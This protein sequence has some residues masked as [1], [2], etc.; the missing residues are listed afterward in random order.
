M[1]RRKR[2][3]PDLI[4]DRNDASD[5]RAALTDNDVAADRQTGKV[6]HHSEILRRKP[7]GTLK[8]DLFSD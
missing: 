3:W 1:R 5:I 4:P 7:G 2:C 8:R 6:R